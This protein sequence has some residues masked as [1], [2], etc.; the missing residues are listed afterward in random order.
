MKKLPEL[1]PSQDLTKDTD[2]HKIKAALKARCNIISNEIAEL[3]QINKLYRK[4]DKLAK[5][6]ARLQKRLNVSEKQ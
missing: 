4:A 5:K 1:F 6:L 2:R 3:K